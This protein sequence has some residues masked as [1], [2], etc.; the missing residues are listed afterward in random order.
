MNF[1]NRTFCGLRQP[2]DSVHELVEP[3]LQPL[4][5]ADQSQASKELPLFTRTS[6]YFRNP[7]LPLVTS[8]IPR[9]TS[10]APSPPRLATPVTL[11]PSLSASGLP[12]GPRGLAH[13]T[14]RP[15]AR[16]RDCPRLP[17]DTLP[18]LPLRY[19]TLDTS[20]T[21]PSCHYASTL[22]ISRLVSPHR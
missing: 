21:A 11:P 5:S 4:S 16:S 22:H 20:P 18:R 14:P 8:P 19:P 10:L 12:Y 2:L 13:V 7:S 9:P 15:W 6:F 1:K 3:S 17:L